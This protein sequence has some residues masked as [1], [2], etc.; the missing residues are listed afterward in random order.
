LFIVQTTLGSRE[1]SKHSNAMSDVMS[2]SS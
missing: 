2:T 1:T